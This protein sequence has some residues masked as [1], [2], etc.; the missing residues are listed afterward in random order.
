M[1]PAQKRAF[2]AILGMIETGIHQLRQLFDDEAGAYDVTAAATPAPLQPQ[3]AIENYLT[4][5]EDEMLEKR[6][7]EERLEIAAQ[8]E[9]FARQ[10]YEV[11]E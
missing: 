6:M 5:N 7:E 9:R 3:R 8:H 1:A 2:L 4:D 11:E 10:F